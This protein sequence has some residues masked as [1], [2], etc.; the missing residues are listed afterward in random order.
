MSLKVVKK[1]KCPVKE[2]VAIDLTWAEE[3]KIGERASVK[4]YCAL[5]GNQPVAFKIFSF[6]N[7]KLP[8]NRSL[9]KQDTEDFLKFKHLN[10]VDC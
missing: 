8:H 5:Y 10:I 1:F 9:V 6:D 3:D 4:V 2:I 7:P